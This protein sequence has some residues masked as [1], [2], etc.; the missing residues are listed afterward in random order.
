MQNGQPGQYQHAR[1]QLLL[2]I[3]LWKVAAF[4]DLLRVELSLRT[5]CKLR[6][7]ATSPPT[8]TVE[9]ENYATGEFL[10]RA[11]AQV[12]FTGNGGLI[13]NAHLPEGRHPLVLKFNS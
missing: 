12:S 9:G 8:Y 2:A 1:F 4:L 7:K 11:I 13:L 3:A 10:Y 6:L 5:E